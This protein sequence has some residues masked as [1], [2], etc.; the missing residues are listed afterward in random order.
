MFVSGNF[1]ADYVAKGVFVEEVDQLF[2]SFN[3]NKHAPAF[4][5]FLRLLSIDSP[6]MGYWDKA[7]TG[8]SS[9]MVNV[10][11]INLLLHKM[12]GWLVLVPSGMCGGC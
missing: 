8:V 9:W 6:H 2:D 7:G 10:P 5:K 3:S 12:G 1:G 4:K 11:L